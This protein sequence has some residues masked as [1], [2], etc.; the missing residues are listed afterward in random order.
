MSEGSHVYTLPNSPT[1]RDQ[2]L[3][4]LMVLLVAVL[5]TICGIK[6]IHWVNVASHQEG[7]RVSL[8]DA[9]NIMAAYERGDHPRPR[10][11][12]AIE[13]S[14]TDT[15]LV[16]RV[17]VPADTFLKALLPEQASRITVTPDV[18]QVQRYFSKDVVPD[19]QHQ[20]ACFVTLTKKE[21]HNG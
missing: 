8:M 5:I 16:L 7:I 10:S 19:Y 6:F 11:N 3:G 9:S 20:E 21:P 12:H 2:Y 4:L 15:Q 18:P 1:H 17:L 14:A 13:I